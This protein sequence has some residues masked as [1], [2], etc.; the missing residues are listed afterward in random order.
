MLSSPAE[1]PAHKKIA[2]AA[3]P[4]WPARERLGYEKELLGFYL[5]GHPLD[6]YLSEI[7]ALQ[8]H[9]VADLAHLSQGAETRLAGLLVKTDV[10]V[11]KKDKKPWARYTF[12]DQSGAT[13][14]LV[15][16]DTYAGLTRSL[17]AGEVVVIAGS[18]DLRDDKPKLRATQV[19][20]LEEARTSLYQT[21][22]LDLSLGEWNSERLGKLQSLVA[23][24]PGNTRL[25][26][27]CMNAGGAAVD[28][29]ASESFKF[30]FNHSFHTG[31]RE[32][33]P[34][35]FQVLASKQIPR[36][37]NRKFFNARNGH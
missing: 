21:F 8:L 11:S 36:Q 23:Q 9:T 24:H 5:T 13:E 20:A 12:E 6:E 19:L 33:T 17:A 1:T 18:V 37:P 31:L 14:V 15:F 30:E 28:L 22:V 29:E 26:L 7:R 4:E 2:R 25:I 3:V 35:A 32:L 10:L 16:P 27:R 34:A